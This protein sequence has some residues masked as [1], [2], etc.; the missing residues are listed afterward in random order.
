MRVVLEGVLV[1]FIH[2]YGSL[3]SRICQEK[4]VWDLLVSSDRGEKSA[5]ASLLMNV[6][7]SL[8]LNPKS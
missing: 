6:H 4:I 5:C 7:K 8:I 2:N 1:G 3:I